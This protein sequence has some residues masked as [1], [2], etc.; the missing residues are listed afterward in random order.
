M[1]YEKLNFHENLGE[2]KNDTPFNAT[3]KNESKHFLSGWRWAWG[4]L[5]ASFLA[6]V[7]FFGYTH[8]LQMLETAGFRGAY[9]NPKT[10]D[11]VYYFLMGW[12]EVV[13]NG[14]PLIEAGNILELSL[15]ILGFALLVGTVVTVI[16]WWAVSLVQKYK[17][18]IEKTEK[19]DI[20]YYMS[21]ILVDSTESLKGFSR[22]WLAMILLL[23]STAMFEVVA[24][25][26]LF[27]LSSF[28]WFLSLAGSL[29]GVSAGKDIVID[30]EC[31]QR[32]PFE[33]EIN[34]KFRVGCSLM[35]IDGKEVQGIRIY[36]DEKHIFFLGDDGAYQTDYQGNLVLF[37]PIER[38]KSGEVKE[39]GSK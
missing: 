16:F 32:E 35:N 33:S 29:S 8:L 17:L 34:D 28:L 1:D 18:G 7:P 24:L 22:L 21:K 30:T 26:S 39:E 5:L 3:D 27:I 13:N 12:S 4:I 25:I 11:L 14:F 19:R 15:K 38:L 9:I 31:G 37:S 2:S 6:W 20:Y 23:F 10:Y 36:S